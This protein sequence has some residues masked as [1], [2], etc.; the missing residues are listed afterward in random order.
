MDLKLKDHH[1]LI[2]GGSKGIG[3]AC[4]H[5]FLA[6][7]ARVTL[8]A[9]NPQTLEEARQQQGSLIIAAKG[10]IAALR[11]AAEEAARADREVAA[12]EGERLRLREVALAE[13]DAF[14]AERELSIAERER[15]GRL[16]LHG[17]WFD[18]ALG[19]LHALVG[20][21]WQPQPT[22]QAG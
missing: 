12:A 10:E 1:V 22:D 5:A 4:A 19:E 8:V 7:G 20:D 3:L 16:A 21:R 13:R 17:A 11:A 6:E 18:I 2:T 9:R 15:A 14:F